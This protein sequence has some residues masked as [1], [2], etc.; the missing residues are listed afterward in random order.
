MNRPGQEKLCPGFLIQ[1]YGK[2]FHLQIIQNM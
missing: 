2:R 1:K